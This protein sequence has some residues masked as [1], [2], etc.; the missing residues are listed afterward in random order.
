MNDFTKNTIKA[1]KV[2]EIFKGIAISFIFTLLLLLI[3]SI[4]LTY[5]E[6]SDSIVPVATIIITAISILVG[7][8]ISTI[9]IKKNG[10]L[11]GGVIGGVYILSIYL[12]SSIIEVGFGLGFKSIIM[13]IVG[14]LSGIIGGIVGVNL[15][16]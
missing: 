16:K 9:K 4:I 6:I 3:L 10:I 15:N 8:S 14:V 13:M 12:I 2:V 7:S 5:T 11:N 1:N